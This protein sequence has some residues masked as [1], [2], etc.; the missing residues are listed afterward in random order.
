[1]KDI[2][3]FRRPLVLA[4][5]FVLILTTNAFLNAFAQSR[6]QPPTTNE[7]KNQR[8]DPAK[9]GEKPQDPLPGDVI[10]RQQ[11][12][13]KVTISTAVVSVDAVVYHK[14]SGQIVP[15]LKQGNFAIFVD[16]QPMPIP[17]FPLRKLPSRW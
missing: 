3:L 12:A 6:R 7:K 13:E 15:G 14:K 5:A 10:N 9:T 16:G 2:A 17:T 8:P 11:D 4:T 1:M